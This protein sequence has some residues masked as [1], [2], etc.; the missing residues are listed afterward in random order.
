VVQ[1]HLQALP[2]P[3]PDQ[4]EE[5]RRETMKI[6][7]K[8]RLDFLADE[9]VRLH[10]DDSLCIIDNK[11]TYGCR[12]RLRNQIDDALRRQPRKKAGRR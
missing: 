2:A 6:T 10:S 4:E 11:N 8:M 3:P 12:A 5:E 1:R 7:D 9:G